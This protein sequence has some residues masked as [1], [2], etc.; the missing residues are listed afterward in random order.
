MKIQIQIFNTNTKRSSYI[1]RRAL[2]GVWKLTSTNQPNPHEPYSLLLY[3]IM[4]IMIVISVFLVLSSPTK[5]VYFSFLYFHWCESHGLLEIDLLGLL[6][7]LKHKKKSCHIHILLHPHH[8]KIS[9]LMG[10][11]WPGFDICKAHRIDVQPQS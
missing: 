6:L 7:K 3:V 5:I 10:K 1:E 9:T 11:V 2:I 4:I 8:E